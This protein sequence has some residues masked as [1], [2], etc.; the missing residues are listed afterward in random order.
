LAKSAQALQSPV[1]AQYH[2]PRAAAHERKV[3][4][5]D[6]MSLAEI[7][8]VFIER[9]KETNGLEFLSVEQL[10]R[11]KFFCR[12]EIEDRGFDEWQKKA[13]DCVVE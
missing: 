1:S 12:E 5:I 11:I 8:D 2:H 6:D 4:N 9:C 7:A 10:E 13:A 3:M